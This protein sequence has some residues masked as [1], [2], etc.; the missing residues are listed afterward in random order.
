MPKHVYCYSLLYG[1]R[2]MCT[3]NFFK[4]RLKCYMFSL[5]TIERNIKCTLP[6][7]YK[8]PRNY[9]AFFALSRIFCVA[10][11]FHYIPVCFTAIN[12]YK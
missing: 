3:A 1:D 9:A 5:L 12:M 4:D 10:F 7:S 6:L 8:S 11:P 2:H